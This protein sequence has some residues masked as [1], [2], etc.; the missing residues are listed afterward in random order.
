MHAYIY[1]ALIALYP[2]GLLAEPVA[3]W[4]DIGQ[5]PEKWQQKVSRDKAK[6][7]VP[8]RS[9]IPH[10]IYP[11]AH[12]FSATWGRQKP[13][14]E[15]THNWHKYGAVI[16]LAQADKEMVVSW[17]RQ[18]LP[19]YHQYDLYDHVVLTPL[20]ADNYVQ[21]KYYRIADPHLVIKAVQSEVA[22][23]GYYRTTIKLVPELIE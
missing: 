2:P 3:D 8:E 19:D 1:F 23:A 12:F 21:N 20:S 15:L 10:P 18:H 4:V 9:D 7:C 17:Y 13:D 14:C 16:L 11:D 6:I 5:L 22:E